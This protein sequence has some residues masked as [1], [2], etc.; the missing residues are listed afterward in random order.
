MDWLKGKKTFIAAG[1]IALAG[2]V[3]F[4]QGSIGDAQL[5]GIL[6]VA[7]G[8]AGYRDALGGYVPLIVSALEEIKKRQGTP[9]TVELKAYTRPAINGGDWPPP[10]GIASTDPDAVTSVKLPEPESR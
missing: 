7:L 4:F 5:I 3:G 10:P 2:I 6:G 9:A 1:L 8:V